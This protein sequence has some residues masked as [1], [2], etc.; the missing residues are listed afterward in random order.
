MTNKTLYQKRVDSGVIEE[1][2]TYP[3]E[4]VLEFFKELQE[5]MTWLSSYDFE[6]FQ[7]TLKLKAGKELL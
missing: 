6:R 7:A 5:S 2:I 1:R 3:E 4:S